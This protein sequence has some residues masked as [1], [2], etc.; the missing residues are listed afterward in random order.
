MYCISQ[1]KGAELMIKTKRFC[2]TRYIIKYSLHVAE[3]SLTS[4]AVPPLPQERE[5]ADLLG[6]HWVTAAHPTSS[7]PYLSKAVRVEWPCRRS[8]HQNMSSGCHGECVCPQVN[9]NGAHTDNELCFR[10]PAACG[11]SV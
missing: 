5:T 8:E 4:T 3:Q 7:L 10:T 2:Y 11:A 1:Q 9:L 6:M